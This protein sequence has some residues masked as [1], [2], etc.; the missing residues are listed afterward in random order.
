MTIAFYTIFEKLVWSTFV[1]FSKRD[2]SFKEYMK[3]NQEYTL[4]KNINDANNVV[5]YVVYS[6]IKDYYLKLDKNIKFT[7]FISTTNNQL[8]PTNAKNEYI[9][10]FILSQKYY[11]ALN[12]F[13][14]ICKTKKSTLGC[15]TDMYMNPIDKNN[16]NSIE[17]LHETAKYRFTYTDLIKIIHKSLHNNEELYAEPIPIKNPYNNLPFL[18]SHLY[19]IYFAIKKSDYNIPMVF[20][21]FFECNFSIATFIDQY[22]F[23]LRD[24]AI[25]EKCKSIDTDTVDEIY[26]TILEMIET[27]NDCHPA[28]T[29]FIHPNFPKNIVLNVF[30]CY[31]KYYYKSMYSLNAG[32]KTSYKIYYKSLLKTFAIQNKMFGRRSIYREMNL[33]MNKKKYIQYHTDCSSFVPPYQYDVDRQ[34]THIQYSK[35]EEDFVLKYKNEIESY[36]KENAHYTNRYD[37]P[38]TIQRDD[39][40]YMLSVSQDAVANYHRILETQNGV[41]TEMSEPDS[42]LYQD[43]EVN[44]SFSTV[45]TLA[46]DTSNNSDNDSDASDVDLAMDVFFDPDDHL[47]SSQDSN[48]A[49]IESVINDVISQI[50]LHEENV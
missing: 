15:T 16:N 48:T 37:V 2:L 50:Q 39:Q 13:A 19:H 21:Q 35:K 30:R 4:Q 43:N 17:I 41:G 38:I 36:A 22:E 12:K 20:H 25:V 34:N 24:K 49:I 40:G 3:Y 6:Q 26:E 42:N 33:D 45:N 11:H 28:Q 5:S 8:L 1:K 18:K 29:I 7:H 23:R 47:H 46:M 9:R 32:L 10:C 31:V 44:Q 14:L 27:Y